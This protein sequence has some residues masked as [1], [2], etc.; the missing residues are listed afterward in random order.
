[1][2]DRVA[3]PIFEHTWAACRG[4]RGRRLAPLEAQANIRALLLL[5]RDLPLRRD[6]LLLFLFWL[7]L[8]RMGAAVRYIM[9]QRRAQLLAVVGEDLRV[10]C[11]ARNGNV[12]HA[13]V[14]QVFGSQLSI[15]VNQHPVGSLPLAGV[16]GHGVAVVKMRML[17]RVKLHLTASVHLHGHAP[18]GDALHGAKLT[19]RQ[20][21]LRHGS[22]ELH[23]VSGRKRPLLL[24]IDRDALLT[25]WIVALLGAILHLNSE[26][27]VRRIYLCHSRILAFWDASLLRCATV[28]QHIALVVSSSPHAVGSGEVLARNKHLRWMLFFADNALRL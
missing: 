24:T 26:P 6:R 25:A 18:L 14:E 4:R 12:G 9:P 11:A 23:P 1:M 20:L 16:A 3:Y 5:R 27:I 13:V 19:V 21:H 2:C 8:R 7:H 28:A 15:G 22:G 10:V 17:N